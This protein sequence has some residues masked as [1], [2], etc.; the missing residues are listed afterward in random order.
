MQKYARVGETNYV[1][2]I[3]DQGKYHNGDKSA[4]LGDKLD[5][6]RIMQL[7]QFTID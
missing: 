6:G 3:E 5:Q 2:N 7:A 1:R 4:M